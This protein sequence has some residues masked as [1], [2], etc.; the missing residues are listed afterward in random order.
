VITSSPV[1]LA[2]DY[3]VVVVG[4]GP[5]GLAAAVGARESGA[6]RVLVVDREP[7]PGGILNQCIHHGFG[8]HHFKEELTGPEYAQ[9]FVEDAL[10][11]GVDVVTDAFVE[12]ARLDGG[13]RAG[14]VKLMTSAAGVRRVET[15]TVVLAMGLGSGPGERSGSRAPV[16]PG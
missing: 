1:H 15:R 14:S 2:S 12:D 4:A 5:A 13:P 10:D 7:E 6:E 8:L 9:R 16:P 11:H 3:E